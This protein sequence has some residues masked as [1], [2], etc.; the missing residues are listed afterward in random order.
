MP[1]SEHDKESHQFFKPNQ[2]NK[3]RTNN[4]GLKY[5]I[6]RIYRFDFM[7][8]SEILE[9]Y[10]WNENYSKFIKMFEKTLKNDKISKNSYFKVIL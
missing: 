4:H 7:D 5:R 3:G 8:I 9:K 6:L 1:H 2:R 10:R